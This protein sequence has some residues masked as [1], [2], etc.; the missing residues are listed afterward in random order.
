MTRADITTFLHAIPPRVASSVLIGTNE[1]WKRLM[2]ARNPCNTACYL[3]IQGIFAGIDSW[4]NK[5]RYWGYPMITWIMVQELLADIILL[6]W[7]LELDQALHHVNCL[8][9][10]WFKERTHCKGLSN[11]LSATASTGAFIVLQTRSWYFA[12]VFAVGTLGQLTVTTVTHRDVTVLTAQLRYWT[13]SEAGQA[14][15]KVMWMGPETLSRSILKC[16]A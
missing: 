10:E 6:G 12:T 1:E 5:L 9:I 13:R 15:K 2:Q 4:G 14:N 8:R 16:E 3:R 11:N 7:S